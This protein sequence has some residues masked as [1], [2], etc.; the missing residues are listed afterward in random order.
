MALSGQDIAE[1]TE[2]LTGTL[3]EPELADYVQASTG[4]GLY[5]EY[6]GP[7]KP[8]KPTIRELLTVLEKAGTAV[9][10][11][12]Y[13]YIHRQGRPDVQRLIAEK[14]PSA[15]TLEAT[16]DKK[17]T[18]VSIQKAGVAEPNAPTNAVA[19]G[20]QRNVRPYLPDLDVHIWLQRSSEI[21]RRI[22]RIERAQQALGTGF[23]IGPDTV[24]T[25]WH[26]V[27]QARRD[28]RISEL[29]CRFDYVRLPDG[30]QQ[31][32]QLVTLHADGCFDSS[33]YSTAETTKT[34]ETPPPTADELDYALLRLAT[35]VGQQR[36]WIALP[37]DA[38][39]L[40][41][42]APLLIMQHPKGDPMKLALDTQ[43]VIGRAANNMRLRYRTNT[44]PGS[45]GS[46]CFT[47][48]WGIVALH[49]Y[50][51]PDWQTPLFNQGVPIELIRRR[52]EAQGLR[53]RLEA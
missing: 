53:A 15:P 32:G 29:G 8:L 9:L 49:H 52:I 31:A 17:S 13:V 27:E 30:S 11:L 40:P 12:H 1:L 33:S 42:N 37:K 18:P 39:P 46:P 24:L 4:D 7:G 48:D 20:F 35:P 45:S 28:D 44:D 16:P 34:P 41:E 19:P 43:A 51:D 25:N 6:V 50:G 10:F 5:D 26:V 38:P 47:L 22:C 23:L 21:E 14:S 36:G 2:A 3:T